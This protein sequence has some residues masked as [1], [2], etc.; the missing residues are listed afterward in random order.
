MNGVCHMSVCT[1]AQLSGIFEFM[2]CN[3]GGGGSSICPWELTGG[4][5]AGAWHS[6]WGQALSSL[7]LFCMIRLGSLCVAVVL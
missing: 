1:G 6:S 4:A 7:S 3:A 2:V 5:G